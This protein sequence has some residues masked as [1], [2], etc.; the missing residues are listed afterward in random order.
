MRQCSP[1][2]HV[3]GSPGTQRIDLIWIVLC[4]Q[5]SE[6]DPFWRRRKEDTTPP[7]AEANVLG[8]RPL[9]SV[10]GAKGVEFRAEVGGRLHSRK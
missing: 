3:L 7:F 1:F 9:H 10:L 4:R 6:N 8:Q 2:V 5:I